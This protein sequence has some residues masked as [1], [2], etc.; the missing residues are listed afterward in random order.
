VSILNSTI[1]ISRF[2]C[3]L[4]FFCAFSLA[5]AQTKSVAITNTQGQT[6]DVYLLKVSK[7]EVDVKLASNH[8]SHV[9]KLTDLDK[10][11][12][13]KIKKWQ[14]AG[15]GLSTDFKIEFN[16]GRSSRSRSGYSD[17]RTFI[18][19]PVVTINNND[20]NLETKPVEVTIIILGKMASDTSLLKVFQKEKHTLPSINGGGEH[21]IACK[22]YRGVYDDEG[23]KY[24]AKYFG[25]IVLIHEGKNV[26][27][28]KSIPTAFAAKYGNQLLKI[29]E[30]KI[31]DKH[32]EV[33]KYS[34]Y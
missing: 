20:N 7:N 1:D 21:I 15:G 25:Y 30:D 22:G 17:E 33:V 26:L 10:A 8:K 31:Y 5:T 27:V 16:S 12:Q 18:L 24:G 2:L 32:L 3:S 13:D 4:I 6:I 28:A 23:Y 11:S 19:K 29:E 14:A 34:D 9:L